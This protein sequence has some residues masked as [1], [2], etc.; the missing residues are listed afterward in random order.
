[1][2]SLARWLFALA[3]LALAGTFVGCSDSMIASRDD[4]HVPSVPPAQW[5]GNML[6]LPTQNSGH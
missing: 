3:V 2:H 6:G 5:E 4:Q 1:M